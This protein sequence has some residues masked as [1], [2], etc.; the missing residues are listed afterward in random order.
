[1]NGTVAERVDLDEARR[2]HLAAWQIVNDLCAGKKRWVMSVPAEPDRD[3]DL[4][5]GAALDILRRLIE[6]KS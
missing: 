6:E 3:P 2:L 4:V 5:I 1:M